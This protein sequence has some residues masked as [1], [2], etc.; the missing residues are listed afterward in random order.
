MKK[1]PSGRPI[2]RAERRDYGMWAQRRI[3]FVCPRLNP[4]HIE[5]ATG[6]HAVGFIDWRVMA[7]QAELARKPK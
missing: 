2:Y 5:Q 6:S 7:E 1:H 4:Q 3:G